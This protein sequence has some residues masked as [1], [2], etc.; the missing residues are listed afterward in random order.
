VVDE[1][2]VDSASTITDPEMQTCMHESMM[3]MAF[4]P[5]PGGGSVS[6]PFPFTLVPGDAGPPPER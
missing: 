1:A 6:V 4:K 5:P 3:A 2:E